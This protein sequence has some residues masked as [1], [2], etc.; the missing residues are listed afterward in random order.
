[1]DWLLTGV[2]RR[3]RRERIIAELTDFEL[4]AIVASADELVVA[5]LCGDPQYPILDELLTR[6]RNVGLADG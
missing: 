2:G 5:G 4:R 6:L 3:A 1:M